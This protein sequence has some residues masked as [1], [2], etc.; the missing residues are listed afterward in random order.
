MSI[1][2]T[3]LT[4]LF[5]RKQDIEVYFNF[6]ETY[7]KLNAFINSE[8]IQ[9]SLFLNP[10]K[11]SRISGME[12][13]KVLALFIYIGSLKDNRIFSIKYRYTCG[14]GTDSF[15]SEAEMTEFKCNEDCGCDEDFDLKEEIERGVVDAPIYFQIDNQLKLS[16]LDSIIS[17]R[18]GSSFRK[19]IEGGVGLKVLSEELTNSPELKHF[20]NDPEIAA[21][22][23]VTKF[24]KE[25]LATKGRLSET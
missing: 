19:E 25:W 11:F 10:Y 14:N 18:N 24:K 7:E 23:I 5:Q 16:I 17:S 15:L 6:D 8:V 1:L 13:S 21:D 2:K 20:I 3:N 12:I 9:G 4:I 22:L